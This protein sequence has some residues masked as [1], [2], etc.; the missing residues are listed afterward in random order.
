MI[1]ELSLEGWMY[2]GFALAAGGFF[3]GSAMHGV[4]GD[5][6]FG[7]IGNMIVLMLGA[8]VAGLG[9]EY[10]PYRFISDP[11]TMAVI[12]VSGA[13]ITLSLLVLFKLGMN[14]IGA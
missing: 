11:T 5:E 12:M 14:K 1:A 9:I 4:L 3:I 13:F 7:P 8:I 10:T 6:G 2:L